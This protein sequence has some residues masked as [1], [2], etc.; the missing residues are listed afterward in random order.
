VAGPTALL[1]LVAGLLTPSPSYGELVAKWRGQSSRY[2]TAMPSQ[3][4]H[5]R[6]VGLRPTLSPLAGSED[7]SDQEAAGARSEGP[8]LP[9]VTAPDGRSRVPWIPS[10]F[11]PHLPAQ[12]IEGRGTGYETGA[13]PK[14]WIIIS[15]AGAPAWGESSGLAASRPNVQRATLL[16]P[17]DKTPSPRAV[18]TAYGE[19]NDGHTRLTDKFG[20]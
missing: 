17:T 5:A 8:A 15:Q 13:Y 10:M 4:G 9:S 6:A 11:V 16:E 2:R 14:G 12:L 18:V 20:D 3:V 19:A 7:W 1:G